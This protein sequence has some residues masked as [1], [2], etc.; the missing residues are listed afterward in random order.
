MLS[1]VLISK[2]N[3]LSQKTNQ[4][5]LKKTQKLLIN[6]R[7]YAK[8]AILTGLL[9]DFRTVNSDNIFMVILKPQSVLLIVFEE[10]SVLRKPSRCLMDTKKCLH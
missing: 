1:L 7:F 5:K 3:E 10:S 9:G 2:M 8:K 6:Q 4:L